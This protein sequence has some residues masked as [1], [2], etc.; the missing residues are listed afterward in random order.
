[1]AISPGA[2]WNRKTAS[3][4]PV[5][6]GSTRAPQ[7]PNPMRAKPSRGQW[8]R[9]VGSNYRPLGRKRDAA[10]SGSTVDTF[11]SLTTILVWIRSTRR[12]A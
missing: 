6:A 3:Q 9:S 5:E 4:G 10:F 7:L 12:C 1:M 8:A 11:T 2:T